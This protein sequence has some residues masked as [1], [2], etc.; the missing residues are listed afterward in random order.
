M[1]AQMRFSNE[2]YGHATSFSNIKEKITGP[3]GKPPYME[4][5][6]D[7]YYIKTNETNQPSRRA[8][9]V[10]VLL[11]RNSDLNGVVTSMKQMEDR[12]N[13]KFQ[14]PY[15]FLNDQ[16]FE[17]SFKKRVSKLTDAKVEFGLI[18]REHW[19][20]PDSI[21]EAKASAAREAM[22][23]NKVI[24]GEFMTENADLIPAGNALSFLSDDG[25][26]TYN[27][28]HF[29]SNFEIADLDL[30]RSEAYNKYFDFLD[31]KGGFYYEAIDMNLSNTAL[32]GK[33]IQEGNAGVM[34]RRI[35]IT[36][37]ILA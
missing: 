29:W 16:E 5:V 37:G 12:F 4:P 1:N 10:F 27:R 7:E 22:V 33:P 3:S 11:A 34:S 25:G 21:D 20:Q 2:K 17:E 26:Q 15:V 9:A 6:P 32:K 28:C 18:P 35:S 19:V 14:Y 30:W 8:N 13:K 31:E 24:Y 36:S 23:N